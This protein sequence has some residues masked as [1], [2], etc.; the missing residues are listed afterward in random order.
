MIYTM[1]DFLAANWIYLAGIGA[2]CAVFSYFSE[3][4]RGYLKKGVITFAVV[5]V[6]IAGY[7][8]VTGNSI[9]N[10]PGSVDRKLSEQADK[11]ETGHRYYKDY[12]ERYGE[13]PP[14][15]GPK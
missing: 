2:L 14:D 5:F 7:E 3:I 8:L 4:F 1:P 15:E 11:V 6:L 10:L 12:D 13:P 9:F